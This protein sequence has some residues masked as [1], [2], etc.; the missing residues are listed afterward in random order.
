VTRPKKRLQV[1]LIVLAWVYNGEVPAKRL[2][3]GVSKM[4]LPRS[5]NLPRKLP[6]QRI[7][8]FRRINIHQV[9]GAGN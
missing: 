7:E 3:Q 1:K 2:G 5:E 8:R 6:Q 9:A 4:T